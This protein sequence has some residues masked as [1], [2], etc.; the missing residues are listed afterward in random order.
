[1]A[2]IIALEELAVDMNHGMVGWMAGILRTDQVRTL[3]KSTLIFPLK[4]TRFLFAMLSLHNG[5]LFSEMYY[6]CN[7]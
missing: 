2:I 7:E 6:F 4:L 1:M 3:N 5:F